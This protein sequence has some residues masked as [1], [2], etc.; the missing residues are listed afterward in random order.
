MLRRRGVIFAV[1]QAFVEV[2]LVVVGH[3]CLLMGVEKVWARQ[4]KAG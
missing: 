1:V 3:F 2:S 4:L